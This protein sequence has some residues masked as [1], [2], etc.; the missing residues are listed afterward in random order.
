MGAFDKKKAFGIGGIITVI[1]AIGWGMNFVA[2]YYQAKEGF[3]KSKNP[4]TTTS[5]VETVEKTTK[6]TKVEQENVIEINAVEQAELETEPP[7]EPPT[8]AQPAITYLNTLKVSESSGFYDDESEADDTIGNK[9]LG[10]V[11]T[12][13]SGYDDECYAIYYL[14]GNYKT[15]SGIIAVH[16]Y[17]ASEEEY[18]GQLFIS[19]DDNVIYT[20]E[21]MGRV[22][23]PVEFSVNVENC[24]W[25]KINKVGYA[26]N[27]NGTR[28]IL[29]DW[30]LE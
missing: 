4:V 15:L 29:S 1:G 11:M 2:D 9:Y 10:N 18:N 30:K 20:T 6:A 17:S 5:V 22:S 21:E 28:F 25:L 8:E 24:Q 3:E 19:T 16:D 27:G 12:I 7:T 14:G 13:G 26:F 23:V